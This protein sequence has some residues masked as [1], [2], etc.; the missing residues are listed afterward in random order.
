MLKKFISI[1]FIL[2]SLSAIS[3]ET[4]Q[5]MTWQI[6][7][8]D[9]TNQVNDYIQKNIS[10]ALKKTSAKTSCQDASIIA[11]DWNGRTTDMLSL[12]E[13]HFYSTPRVDRFPPLTR[14]AKGVVEDSIYRDVWVFKLKVF[15]VNIQ[16]NGVYFG[17]DKLGHF[18]TVGRDYYK[19]YIKY[20]NRGK[21]TGEAVE[22]ALKRGVFSERTYYGYIVSGV[23]S[24]ADL[25]ANYQGLE[26]V[27]S[28]C[29]GNN[30][31]LKRSNSG[32]W[33]LSRNIDI[34]PYITPKW[35]ESFYT[36]TFTRKRFKQIK[37]YLKNYCKMRSNPRVIERFDYYRSFSKDN[38]NSLY[39]DN[40]VKRGKLIKQSRH[41]LESICN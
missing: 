15:G 19:S 20:L 7:L 24:F 21:S 5:Y 6:D 17:V 18:I 27:R 28:F 40:L 10:Q 33:K 14:S 4:D 23:F 13:S 30:P 26:F 16:M 29:E 8:N 38:A 35:D 2:F 12:I 25:E 36:S 9:S 3:L 1:F 11:V 39:L 31:L 22:R 37:N 34:S 32:S 41:N